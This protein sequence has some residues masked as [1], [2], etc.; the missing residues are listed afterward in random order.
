MKKLFVFFILL[1][2]VLFTNTNFCQKFM[3]Y[4]TWSSE[5]YKD[6]GSQNLRLDVPYDRIDLLVKGNWN[7]AVDENNIPIK[8]LDIIYCYYQL[9]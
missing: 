9:I 1:T 4:Q 6:P 7:G 2:F 5:K 3:K 8:S